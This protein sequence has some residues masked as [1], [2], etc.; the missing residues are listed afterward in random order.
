MLSFPVPCESGAVVAMNY[1]AWKAYSDRSL[2][3]LQRGA[4][5]PEG[6]LASSWPCKQWVYKVLRGSLLPAHPG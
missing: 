2:P 4:A 6:V 1:A 5:G 3:E